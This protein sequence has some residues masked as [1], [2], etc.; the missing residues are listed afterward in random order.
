MSYNFKLIGY[1]IEHSLSPWIHE[2]FLRKT[3]IQ[4]SYTIN[5][6]PTDAPFAESIEKMKKEKVNGFNVT[7]PYKQK[8][9]PLLDEMDRNAK[10]IGAVNTVLI[11]DG[12]LI[13][14]NTDG[15]GYVRSLENK[16]PNLVNEKSKRI[17]IL[18]AG[19]AARGIY[20]GLSDAGYQHIDIA[21]RTKEKAEEIA[22]IKQTSTETQIITLKE[23]ERN[24]S[25]YDVIIQTTSV[26]MKPEVDNSVVS[27]QRLKPETIVSDIVYQP[28]K[29]TFLKQAKQKGSTIHF[30]HTMLLYQAKL[31][32]EIWTEIDVQIDNMDE[33]LQLILEGR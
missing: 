5:E 33:E 8:I 32:Y 23:A 18:G 1:P 4:G 13:G 31:A 9:I 12:K 20:Y 26:G 22:S 3:N 2:Q 24:L 28:I 27:L 10:N 6:I 7:V 15:K 30:G 19:G 29:T 25:E 21:N 14:Y 17:L 16:I 11:K